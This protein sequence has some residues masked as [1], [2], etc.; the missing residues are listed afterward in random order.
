MQDI[1]PEFVPKFE[2]PPFQGT[3]ELLHSRPLTAEDFQIVLGIERFR[4]PEILFQ[5]SIVGVDQAGLDE[6]VG[7]SL[8]RLSSVDDAIKDRICSSILVTGGSTLFQGLDI[9]L[10]SGIRRIRPFLSPLKLVRASDAILDAW[11]GAALYATASQ[12]PSQ[13]F[14]IQ[15][16]YEKGEG[17]L[18][19]YR[20]K[21]SLWW[22]LHIT[23]MV[24]YRSWHNIPVV[25]WSSSWR[26]LALGVPCYEYCMSN[27]V[28]N[29]LIGNGSPFLVHSLHTGNV[30][31]C[32]FARTLLSLI[33]IACMVSLQDPETENLDWL[34]WLNEC[35]S[36]FWSV[37][38]NL[39]YFY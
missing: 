39:I 2:M 3:P 14:S 9:R 12:F 8:R 35:G 18:R 10:E 16:Y 23:V 15:D 7:I 29:M 1:D 4:C 24:W 36:N 31:L 19:E 38:V 22:R 21:Y 11:R 33:M 26:M 17:A 20:I 5:P 37:H 28:L 32:F 30:M 34:R 13:T 6:M 25:F 27:S